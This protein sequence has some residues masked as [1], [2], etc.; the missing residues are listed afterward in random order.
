MA[1]TSREWLADPASY[2]KYFIGNTDFHTAI[3]ENEL[4]VVALIQKMRGRDQQ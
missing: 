3:E 1:I 2:R 4:K